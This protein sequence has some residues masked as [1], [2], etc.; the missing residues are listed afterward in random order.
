MSYFT[1]TQNLETIKYLAE[2]SEAGTC[3]NLAAKLHVSERTVQRMI[4]Q[5]RGE[6]YPI[7]YNRMKATYE[8]G[9][10]SNPV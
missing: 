5:L 8:S 7:H 3:L 6:G 9:Q 10:K 4:R 1:Y 2:H